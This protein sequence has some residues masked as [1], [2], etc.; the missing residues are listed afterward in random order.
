MKKRDLLFMSFGNGITVC[1]RLHEKHG[2]YETV[3]HIDAHRK[4][5]YRTKL[6]K[7]AIAEIEAEANTADP[8]ISYTQEQKVFR[9]RPQ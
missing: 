7:V 2:D 8:Q 5:T 9:T 3:A 4:I 1:D 6:S